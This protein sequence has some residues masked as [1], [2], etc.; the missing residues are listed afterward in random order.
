M[1]CLIWLKDQI[2]QGLFVTSASREIPPASS[3]LSVPNKRRL[4]A[5]EQ[6]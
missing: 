1:Q 6:K 5:L 4:R 3:L 2:S